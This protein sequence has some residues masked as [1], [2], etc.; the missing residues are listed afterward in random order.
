MSKDDRLKI[1]DETY[2]EP[3]RRIKACV[4]C[5]WLR[6]DS[7][8]SYCGAARRSR[9]C[10]FFAWERRTYLHNLLA[11]CDLWESDDG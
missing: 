10:G 11:I 2:R 3:K 4:N 5:K 7:D 1:R 8:A 6:K 9:L